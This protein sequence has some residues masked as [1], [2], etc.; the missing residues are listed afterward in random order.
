[1][2]GIQVTNPKYWLDSGTINKS[3]VNSYKT[4]GER[5]FGNIQ[6]VTLNIIFKIKS[7]TLSTLY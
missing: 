6:E 4:P 1:M 5:L 3:L 7:E 2:R